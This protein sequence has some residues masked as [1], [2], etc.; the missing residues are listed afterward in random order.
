V[1]PRRPV[2]LRRRPRRRR[3]DGHSTPRDEVEDPID[4]PMAF[5]YTSGSH[6]ER[7]VDAV[8][9]SDPAGALLTSADDADALAL[10]AADANYE[11]F[12][13]DTDFDRQ[14]LVAGE[15]HRPESV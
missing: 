15:I 10:D 7:L 1:P 2:G 14:F 5:E 13:S 12:V 6:Q 3:A 9:R 8:D 11:R 4:E